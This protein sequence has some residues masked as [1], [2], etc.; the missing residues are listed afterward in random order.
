[1]DLLTG[2]EGNEPDFLSEDR[3]LGNSDSA[4]L[5]DMTRVF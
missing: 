1:M 2:V 3:G 5:R 4:K